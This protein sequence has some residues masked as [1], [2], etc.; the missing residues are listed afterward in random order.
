MVLTARMSVATSIS[1]VTRPQAGLHLSAIQNGVSA[2]TRRAPVVP[3]PRP[4]QVRDIRDCDTK[5][6]MSRSGFELIQLRDLPSVSWTTPEQVSRQGFSVCTRA[7]SEILEA[8]RA[9]T[10]PD[11]PGHSI[12]AVLHLTLWNLHASL[13]SVK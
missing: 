8:S 9:E 6:S 13:E 11:T 3:D 4:V 5:P 12:L 2:D 10:C 1:Y 7:A